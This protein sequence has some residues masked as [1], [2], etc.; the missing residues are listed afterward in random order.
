MTKQ[1]TIVVTGALRVKD[2]SLLS[3]TEQTSTQSTTPLVLHAYHAGINRQTTF[4]NIFFFL[5]CPEKKVKI[6][7]IFNPLN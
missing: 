1:T 2:F 4:L 3:V 6:L 5:F 7:S